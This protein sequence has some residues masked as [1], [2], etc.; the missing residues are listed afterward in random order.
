[1]LWSRP[2]IFAPSWPNALPSPRR[3]SSRASIASTASSRSEIA[4]FRL[5][6][7]RWRTLRDKQVGR[8]RSDHIERGTEDEWHHDGVFEERS[9]QGGSDRLA[10]KVE[11]HRDGEGAAE[12]RG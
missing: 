2:L 3:A 9:G 10:G 4:A 8:G 7:V 5:H 1:M 6:G 11:A 12:P